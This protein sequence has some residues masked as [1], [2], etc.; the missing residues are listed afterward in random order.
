[1]ASYFDPQAGLS[2]GTV[3]LRALRAEDWEALSAAASDPLI[4]EQHPAHDRWKAE[5]F[6]DFFDTA[7]SSGR[8]YLIVGAATGRVLGSSRYH[9]GPDDRSVEIGWTFLIRDVWGTDVNRRVKALMFAHALEHFDRVVLYAGLEN[10]R[11][12]RAIEKV[13]G[14]RLPDAPNSGGEL[15]AM[16]EVVKACG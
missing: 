7:L 13:G 4:W 2:D 5:V 11:S 15:S 8:A 10:F 9:P 12:Q 14:R 1:M 16:Y 3:R 6:R